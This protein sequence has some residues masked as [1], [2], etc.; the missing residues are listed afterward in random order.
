M[1]WELIKRIEK[2]ESEFAQIKLLLESKVKSKKPSL[3]EVKIFFKEKGHPLEAEKFFDY[4]E[5][6]GWRVGKNPMKSWKPAVN[7]WIRN[8]KVFNGDKNGTAQ[9]SVIEQLEYIRAGYSKK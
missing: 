3:D 8:L 4:Y 5:A 2:L 7:N 6:N 9:R 1:E